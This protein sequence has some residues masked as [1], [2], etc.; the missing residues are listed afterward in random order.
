MR[1][2]GKSIAPGIG[3]SK[4]H[5]NLSKVLAGFHKNPIGQGKMHGSGTFDDNSLSQGYRRM[6]DETPEQKSALYPQENKERKGYA[7]L[8]KEVVREEAKKKKSALDEI[9]K[10]L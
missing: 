9:A 5:K 4:Q 2:G 1:F 8:A 6:A 3:K 10:D 7:G